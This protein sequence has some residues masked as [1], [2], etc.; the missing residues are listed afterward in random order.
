MSEGQK[1]KFDKS[2]KSGH[3]DRYTCEFDFIANILPELYTKGEIDKYIMTHPTEWK[4][5]L[6]KK[7][8]Y[9][10]LELMKFQ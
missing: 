6:L 4:N 2:Y 7:E 5:I 1:K 8:F 9:L 10:I 3:L